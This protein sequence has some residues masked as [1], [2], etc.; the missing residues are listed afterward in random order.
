MLSRLQ[1]IEVSDADIRCD[2]QLATR[3]HYN[4]ATA[5]LSKEFGKN[6]R[7]KDIFTSALLDLANRKVRIPPR[8]PPFLSRNIY[9]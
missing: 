3:V 8:S 4:F 2:S 6:R 1:R 5:M 9:Q 7:C